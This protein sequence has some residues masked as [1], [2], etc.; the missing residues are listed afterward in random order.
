MIARR[1]FLAAGLATLSARAGAQGLRAGIVILHGK[2]GM[3]SFPGLRVLASRLEAGGMRTAI[4]EMPWS[5]NRYIDG[6]AG[7]AFDAI[8]AEL[9]RLKAAGAAKLFLAGHSIGATAALGHAV[10]RG[11]VDGIAMIATGHNP[12]TYYNSTQGANPAVHQSIDRARGLV[13][14]GR[15]S[16]VAQFADN[17]QGKALQVRMTASDYLSWFEPDGAMDPFALMPKAP[18]PVLWAIGAQDGLYASSRA[19]YFDRLPPDLHHKFVELAG[20]HLDA[21]AAAAEPVAAFFAS[22]S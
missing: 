10:A 20:G 7:K 18:C 21:P 5:R 9:A 3:P 6:S 16:E 1:V 17:N 12:R 11:G 14:T 22:L 2:T 19:Q 13:A 8:A 4:P 15:G